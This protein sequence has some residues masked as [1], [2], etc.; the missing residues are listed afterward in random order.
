MHQEMCRADPEWYPEHIS[1]IGVLQGGKSLQEAEHC[2]TYLE[3]PTFPECEFEHLEFDLEGIVETV[4]EAAEPIRLQK[5]D[6]GQC[7]PR[8]DSRST[9]QTA[10]ASS[11][12]RLGTKSQRKSKKPKSGKE[13]SSTESIICFREQNTHSKNEAQEAKRRLTRRYV[14]SKLAQTLAPGETSDFEY[15]E[16]GL[17]SPELQLWTQ[18]TN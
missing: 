12:K 7:T 2:D 3:E 9:M 5:L 14:K 18:T 10:S 6:Q 8:S 13:H 4:N 1:L 15:L 16:H 11:N 17:E